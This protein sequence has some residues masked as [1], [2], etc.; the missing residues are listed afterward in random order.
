MGFSLAA[1]SSTKDTPHPSPFVWPM[2][3]PIHALRA[4]RDRRRLRAAARRD[5]AVDGGG[6]RRARGRRHG[7]PQAAGVQPRRRAAADHRRDW[8]RARPLPKA[9]R[10]RGGVARRPSPPV[11]VCR[12]VGWR[13]R[14]GADGGG[15]R[16][17]GRA[18]AR[19]RPP[20]RP[21]PR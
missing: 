16:A 1:D 19:L 17:A 11:A 12:R 20:L 21:Q 6:G 15:R 9:V 18:R 10:H 2:C 13:A 8:G 7:Q 14:A 3:D 4:P 5:G